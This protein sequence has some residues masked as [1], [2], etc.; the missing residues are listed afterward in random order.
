MASDPGRKR[1]AKRNQDSIGIV[2]GDPDRDLPFLLIVADGMGGHIGGEIASQRVVEAI[3]TC[4]SEAESGEN[5]PDLLNTCIGA[6]LASLRTYAARH[7]SHASMGTTV[8]LATVH[9]GQATVANV[10][11]SRAYLVRG[12][13]MI[14]LSLDHSVVAD[15]VRAGLISDLDARNHPNRNRLTQSITPKRREVTPHISQEPFKRDDV[16]LLCTDGLW[17]VVPESIMRALAVELPPREAVK[18]MISLANQNGGPDNI[19]VVIA[20]RRDFQPPVEPG[21][22]TDMAV[23]AG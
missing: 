2:P 21:D 6:A 5:L 16:L 22:E 11:D 17:G 18:R 23:A 7:P 19:S 10:G 12:E 13:E 1:R 9:D 20:R 8:V 15:L 3:K 14:Q 4:Y